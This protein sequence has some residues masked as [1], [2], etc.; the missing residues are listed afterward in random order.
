MNMLL[1]LT[2][3]EGATQQVLSLLLTMIPDEVDR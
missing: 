1:P 3:S 2:D